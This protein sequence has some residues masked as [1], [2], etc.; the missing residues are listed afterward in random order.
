ME[1]N[2]AHS[3]PVDLV[4][5]F[6]RHVHYIY[7]PIINFPVPDEVNY[8]NKWIVR[9][10]KCSIPLVVFEKC[11]CFVHKV[12]VCKMLHLY[13]PPPPHPTPHPN[14]HTHSPTSLPHLL[15][16]YWR[17][18]LWVPHLHR[19]L[20][21]HAD[22]PAHTRYGLCNLTVH[23]VMFTSVLHLPSSQYLACRRSLWRPAHRSSS[24][25]TDSQGYHCHHQR[26]SFSVTG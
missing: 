15:T 10:L 19:P 22:T 12:R 17:T 18:G 7:Y 20:P 13:T 5:Y 4:S 2:H 11:I 24:L 25:C 16:A 6:P 21:T 23:C 26:V 9:V 14:T 3:R 1:T 8:S